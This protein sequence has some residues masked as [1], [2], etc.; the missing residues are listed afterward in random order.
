MMYLIKLAVSVGRFT[1][2]QSM[3]KPIFQALA[4]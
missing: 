3:H 2:G 4:S 1:R